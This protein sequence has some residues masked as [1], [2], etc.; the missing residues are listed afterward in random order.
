M[1]IA[2][3][4]IINSFNHSIDYLCLESGGIINHYIKQVNMSILL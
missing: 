1:I 4:G 2:R 3:I